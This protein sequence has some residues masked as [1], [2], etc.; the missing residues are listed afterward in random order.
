MACTHTHTHTHTQT[1]TTFPPRKDH[2]TYPQARGPHNVTGISGHPLPQ[3]PR[4]LLWFCV[5]VCVCVCVCLF[6]FLPTVSEDKETCRD[7]SRHHTVNGNVS[8]YCTTVLKC[9]TDSSLSPAFF[10]PRYHSDSW[11]VHIQEW[12]ASVS[13]AQ[14]PTS[15]PGTE[16][17]AGKHDCV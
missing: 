14:S 5:C 1:H 17:G 8:E 15:Q 2:S 16:Q 13:L 12:Q 3:D 9:R 10:L 6:L 11:A 4:K 7:Q